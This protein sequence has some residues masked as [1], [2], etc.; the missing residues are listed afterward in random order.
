MFHTNHA[1]DSLVHLDIVAHPVYNFETYDTICSY[2]LPYQ[3]RG[4]TIYGPGKYTDPLKTFLNCD[5]IYTT[6]IYVLNELTQIG[7]ID[8]ETECSYSLDYTSGIYIYTI[9]PVPDA[10]YYDWQLLDAPWHIEHNNG[11]VCTLYVRTRDIGTLTVQAFND[12]GGSEISTITMNSLFG[13]QNEDG[14]SISIYPNPSAD[15]INIKLEKYEGKTDISIYD[16]TGK[17]MDVIELN[18]NTDVENIRYNTTAYRN[19][20]YF[21]RVRSNKTFTTERVVIQH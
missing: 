2:D 18:I 21:I 14:S 4:M 1:C 17:L 20:T 12:C 13:I 6:N 11:T 7:A 10:I 3:W 5:S 8:G 15:Y 16:V 19:G 9:D